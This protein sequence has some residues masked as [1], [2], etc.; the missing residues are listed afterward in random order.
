MVFDDCGY[1]SI[2]NTD[3]KEML[4]RAI[5]VYFRQD[6]DQVYLAI[7]TVKSDEASFTVL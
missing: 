7:I 6:P 1:R 4:M 2:K 3:I 5:N